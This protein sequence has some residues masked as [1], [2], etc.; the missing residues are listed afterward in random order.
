MLN[1]GSRTINRACQSCAGKG[2]VYQA[3]CQKCQ[4]PI[5]Q[6]DPWWESDSITMPCGHLAEKHLVEM[7]TCPDCS[8]TG[9]Q[10]QQISQAEWRSIRRRKIARG[11]VLLIMG[12]VPIGLLVTAFLSNRQGVC[13]SWWYGIITI[14]LIVWYS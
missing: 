1:D 8:G 14:G 3:H 6:D 4:F 9:R 7:T 10:A 5:G 12:L 13:G 2:E 11:F